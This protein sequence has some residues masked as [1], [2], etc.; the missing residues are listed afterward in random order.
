MTVLADKGPKRKSGMGIKSRFL[1]LITS[2]NSPH[3]VAFGIAIGVFIGIMPLYGLHLLLALLFAFI[4]PDVNKFAIF[5]G[6]N[7]SIPPTLPFITWGSYSI[8][9]VILG[10]KT[11][12]LEWGNL[13]NLKYQD[14]PSIY[15][16]LFVGSIIMAIICSALFYFITLHFIEKKRSKR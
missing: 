4:I 12:P 8:G 7:I 3:E 9:R 1:D 10:R 14:I 11:P 2:N 15:I 6:T 5:I 16:P 13:K